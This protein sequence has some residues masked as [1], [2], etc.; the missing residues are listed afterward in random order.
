MSI[1]VGFWKGL[2]ASLPIVIAF[3]TFVAFFMLW[4]L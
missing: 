3:W 2:L 1:D 4:L